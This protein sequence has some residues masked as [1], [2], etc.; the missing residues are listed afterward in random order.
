MIRRLG[1][2]PHRRESAPVRPLVYGPRPLVDP[3]R[4]GMRRN[5]LR[6]LL[7]VADPGWEAWGWGWGWV[8]VGVARSGGCSAPDDDRRR[9]RAIDG[10]HLPRQMRAHASAQLDISIR[11]APPRPNCG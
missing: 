7:I 1:P 3:G 2:H 10:G 4:V 9:R 5:G 6:R 11:P 8:G